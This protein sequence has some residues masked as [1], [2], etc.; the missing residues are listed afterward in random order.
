MDTKSKKGLYIL[1][2]YL[3]PGNLTCLR[4]GFFAEKFS[5]NT[6]VANKCI[7]DNTLRGIFDGARATIEV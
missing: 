5:G 1:T 6:I 3:L 4:I 2:R 7:L